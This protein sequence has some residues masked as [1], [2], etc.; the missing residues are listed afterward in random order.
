MIIIKILLRLEQELGKTNP[1]KRAMNNYFV[2]GFWKQDSGRSRCLRYRVLF[3]LF[4]MVEILISC[5]ERQL[6]I[7]F[8]QKNAK[9]LSNHPHHHRRHHYHHHHRCDSRPASQLYVL[10]PCPFVLQA[11]EYFCVDVCRPLC[12]P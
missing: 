2:C 11:A 12:D 4:L 8:T 3:A 1:K 7:I 5:K 10:Q 6:Y 9:M